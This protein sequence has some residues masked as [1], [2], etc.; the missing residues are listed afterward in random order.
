MRRPR[1]SLATIRTALTAAALVG[2]FV[3]TTGVA[4]AQGRYPSRL[5]KIVVPVPPGAFADTLPR[6]LGEKLAVMWG[7]PV[8]IE[9]RPGAASNLGAE[10]VA[11]A[12][13]DGYTM[14]ATPPGPLVVNQNLYAKLPFDP[15]AFVPV[16]V[17]ASLPYVLLANPGLP[18]SD[19]AQLV[20]YAKANSDK[21]SFGSAGIGSPPH[22]AMEWLKALAGIR[23]THVPY[24]GSGPALADLVAGHIGLMFD[25]VGNPVPLIR[26]GKVRALGVASEQRL[27]ALPDVAPIAETFPTFKVT[28]WFAIVAPPNT[29]PEIAAKLSAAF[30]QILQMP[31]VTRRLQDSYAAPVGGSP[32]DTAALIKNE[33]ERWRKIIQAAGIKPE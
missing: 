15:E 18:F 24:R 17:M 22:L 3:A 20:A 14:L 32:A 10:A 6:L 8:I 26:D 12:A 28:T 2:A 13:P 31:E 4:L 11:K 19:V 25:N 29:P 1:S 9:N 21:L 16:T 7:Q 33:T 30:G 23:M 27:A 5:I